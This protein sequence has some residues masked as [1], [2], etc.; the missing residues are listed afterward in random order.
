VYADLVNL[1]DEPFLVYR[2]TGN[3]PNRLGQLEEYGWSA[4]FGVKFDL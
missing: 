3:K 2:K 4:N 1:T